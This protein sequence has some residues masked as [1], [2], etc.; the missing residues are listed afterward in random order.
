MNK[1]KVGFI[2]S[3][4][5]FT[6]LNATEQFNSLDTITV[7]AALNS[8]QSIKDLTSNTDVITALELEEKNIKTV[9]EALNLLAGISW[10]SNGGFGKATS[11]YLRGFDS[12]MVLVLID[13]VRVND[14]TS[15][16]GASF[17][18]LPISNIEQIEVIKGP[19]SGIWG[20]DASAGV[21]NIITK[22]PK[23]GFNSS[24][25]VEYGSFNTKDYKA[26]ISFK[27][28]KFD[29]SISA[30]KFITDGITA[31]ATKYSD[32]SS[33]E[34]DGYENKS[35]NLKLGYNINEF[36]KVS[37]IHTNIDTFGEYDS[38]NGDS[39]DT[40]KQKESFSKVTFENISDYA[41]STVYAN[42]SKFDRSYSDGFVF[43]GDIL[44]YGLKSEVDYLSN[45]F[46][47]VGTDYK[48]FEHK[49]ELN[50]EFDNYGFFATNSN[51]LFENLVITES[52]RADFYDVFSDKV[53]G[54]AGIKYDFFDDI[55]ISSN[56][57]TA[58]N[59]PSLYKLY[60]VNFGN[61][62]LSP[63]NVKGF[64]LS[65]GFKN[66]KITRFDNQIK[67]M[68]DYDF[69]ISR[70]NNIEGTS[71]L[72]G[73]EFDYKNE[74]FSN[75]LMSV[76]YTILDAKN[77]KSEVLGRR[78]KE[79]FKFGV[80][81][82]GISKLH[83]GTFGE[84]IGSRYDMVNKQGGQSGKYTLMNAVLDYDVS[85]NLK[86]HGTINNIFDKYYQSVN[87]YASLPRAYYVGLR[88]QF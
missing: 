80:D 66:F 42:Y 12:K 58:Y 51:R 67:E 24:A 18:H 63:E 34:D 61:S 1:Q 85:S 16:N 64:D 22:S 62:K 55:Y 37:L 77:N 41:T 76:G 27:D 35:V 49:K 59:V 44:E 83:V 15:L 5:I 17:E 29:F 30:H 25:N 28:K 46:F 20:S 53:T 54:K 48:T 65:V 33:Y 9:S 2:A 57:G 79:S 50:K 60:D 47:I 19:Q 40:Y 10:S 14:P 39:F 38:Y 56:I 23:D 43:D 69:T 70:F 86:L 87:N 82:Y 72:R 11:V 6:S 8:K 7:T 4:L 75:T 26:N 88:Y 21:I 73:Y 3:F 36:N 71:K 52:L 68:I 81:Y 32:I 78:P 31:F 45:G 84:Y 13:G 74:L